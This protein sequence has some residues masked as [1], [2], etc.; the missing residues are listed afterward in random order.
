M[1][2]MTGSRR[3]G[4]LVSLAAFLLPALGVSGLAAAQGPDVGD[5]VT[6]LVPDVSEF[7]DPVE[8]QD[9][10]CAAVTEHAYW[11]VQDTTWIAPDTAGVAVWGNYVNQAE[12][13]A[14]TADFEGGSVDVYGTVTG[15]FGPVPDTDGDPRI[16]IVLAD[17]PDWYQNQTGGPSR[18]GRLAHIEPADFDGT[19]TFNN[20]DIVYMNVGPFKTNQTVAKQ[21]RLW[22]LPSGLAMLI[23]H[24]LVPAEDLWVSRGL[25]QVAQ[26]LCYGLTYVAVGPN[27]MGVQGN[28]T[29]FETAANIEL[30]NWSSGG[31][32]LKANDF[33][34]NLGQEFLWFMY[35]EQR[36]PGVL[37]DVAQSDTTGMLGIAR[38]IDSS[39]PDSMAIQTNVFPIY[40]DWLVTN[41]VNELRSPLY[42]G[43]YTYAFLEGE[44]YQ[45]SHSSKEAA[46]TGKFSDYPMPI[47]IADE[48]TGMAAPAFAC[49]YC[50]FTGDYT[51]SETVYFNGMF[52]DGGGSGNPIDGAWT[53]GVASLNAAG[54]ALSSVEFV[55]LDEY[56]NGSFSL[57]GG[58]TNYLA[59]TNNNIGG[60]AE[61]RYVLSQDTDSPAVLVA[62]LQNL[63]NPQYVDVY[64]TPY[65]T[66]TGYIEGFDWYGPI[67]TASTADS[68]ASIKM[69]SFEETVWY[70][71]FKAWDAGSYTMTVAGF[72]STGLPIE[73]S[74]ELAVGY[75]EG[76]GMTLEVSNARLDVPAGAAAPGQTVCL[77]QTD[78]L[79]LS[80]ASSLPIDAVVPA[81]SG[82]VEGPVSIGDV[83]GTI[84]FPASDRD[85][86]VYRWNGEAWT[87]LDSYWQSGRMCAAV[88]E[89]GI[90]VYG[91]APGVSSPSLPAVLT[92]AGN[93]PNPFSAETVISFSMPS[94][95]RA[96]L[97]V[98]DMAGRVVRTLA[99]EDLPAASHA[100]VWDGRDDSGNPVGAGIYFCRLEASGRSAVQKMI[101]VA[102]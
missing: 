12:I 61:L 9:F 46:F 59:V 26:Y 47:W 45:F 20:H 17:I 88:S 37:S 62:M 70:S 56:Y 39:V 52:N 4:L 11:L 81:M 8:E 100:V 36:V 21:L 75:A 83:C 14:L 53:I 19:G 32:G 13:D 29:K 24:G 38:A 101:R 41:V 79:G 42:G 64:S 35:L 87:Q 89:G 31:Q 69:L 96:T 40:N 91:T 82:I 57:S 2:A 30:T 68:T 60:Q 98:F 6:L 85:G 25:G 48:A 22:Y 16:W 78:L 15:E 99:D 90:Y 33:A 86:A 94:A 84:S 34:A 76:A 7:P 92:L 95:G 43:N 10:Y 66:T 93:A 58:G 72:D 51:G 54:D 74:R 73:S 23:R 67:F 28:M 18:V 49:Q 3:T 97:R 65:N 80:I 44:T 1:T 5:V 71:R 50:K 63:A 55:E 77:M 102:E 27:K